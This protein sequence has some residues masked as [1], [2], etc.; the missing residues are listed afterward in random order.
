MVYLDHFG[1]LSGGELALARLL[2][3]LHGVQPHVMLAED[4]PL[5]RRL[6]ASGISVEVFPM[7]ACA[8]TLRRDRV[9]FGGT[10]LGAV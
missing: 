6:L 9:R 7:A 3:A 8:R 2:P 4:G 1:G 10:S 5:V